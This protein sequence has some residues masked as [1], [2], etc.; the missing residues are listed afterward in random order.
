MRVR[1]GARTPGLEGW[2]A[3]GTLKLAVREPPEEGRANRALLALIARAL[4]V[5]P[6]RVQLKAG[7]AQRRK[8]I[9]VE[10]LTRDEVVRRLDRA[11]ERGA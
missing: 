2:M 9:E 3:D 10:G 5:E 1:P 6:A 4:G 11:L 7:A 8:W